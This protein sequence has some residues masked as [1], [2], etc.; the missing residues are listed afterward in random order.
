MVLFPKIPS[1]PYVLKPNAFNAS[2]AINTYTPLL[3]CL[4]KGYPPVLQAG[5][6]ERL[7]KCTH[8]GVNDAGS[9]YDQLPD[10]IATFLILFL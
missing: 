7:S 2:C 6:K 5:G 4:T 3:P 1:K 10:E 8:V 9:T